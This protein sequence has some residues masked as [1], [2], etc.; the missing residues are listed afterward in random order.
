[1]VVIRVLFDEA[2]AS[3]TRF[4]SVTSWLS[5][6]AAGVIDCILLNS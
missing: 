4:L 1:M 2:N 6:G 3:V 5:L